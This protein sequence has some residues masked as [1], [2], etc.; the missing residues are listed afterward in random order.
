MKLDARKLAA[1]LVSSDTGTPLP[2]DAEAVEKARR[3][4]AQP[5][6][7]LAADVESLPAELAEAVLEVC[8]QKR[9]VALA[10]VLA[11]SPN[12]PIAKAAKKALY[13]LRSAGEAIPEKKPVAPPP[14]AATATGPAEET[15]CL[16]S[17]I[18]GMGERALIVPRPVRAGGLDLFQMVLQDELGVVHLGR[19]HSTRSQYRHQVR[20][21]RAGRAPG[22]VEID[23]ANAVELLS[24]A[25]AAN[26]RTR[27]P[28]PAGLEEL[29]GA[30]GVTPRD[31]PPDL[32]LPED[33]DASLAVEGH[34]LH[35]EPELRSWLPP[36]ED[37]RAVAQ[38]M[39]QVTASPLKLSEAQQGQQLFELMRKSAEDFFTPVRK[40]LYARRLWAMADVFERTGRERQ[41]RVARA[42]ARRLFHDA[43]GFFSK[44]AEFL[45]E[46]VLHITAA[47]N[48]GK[49]PP[50]PGQP[51]APGAPEKRP[52]DAKGAAPGE[53]RS[54][55]GLIL[56]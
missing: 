1:A 4:A 43:P 46:K 20:E 17:P 48:A 27:T 24:D 34:T 2:F 36:E 11:G 6:P 3:I 38:K 35:D 8:V 13:R 49:A 25:I 5:D 54:P 53:K 51:P 30:L 26:L 15:P 45:F 41:G 32:P 12:K 50:E 23:T 55:G 16:L 47:M 37:L 40:K 33:G 19:H 28:F 52:E 7:T 9:A 22:A 18:S 56:P 21:I 44:F 39:D 10:D 42:E 29:I 14:P 31:T